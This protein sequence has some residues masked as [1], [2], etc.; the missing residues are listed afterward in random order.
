MKRTRNPV[1]IQILSVVEPLP[2]CTQWSGEAKTS[3]RSYQWFYSADT[4]RLAVMAQQPEDP[5]LFLYLRRVPAAFR[6]NVKL[7]VQFA[8]VASQ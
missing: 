3:R 5:R 7:A 4:G 1:Q 8:Q 2:R 6:T